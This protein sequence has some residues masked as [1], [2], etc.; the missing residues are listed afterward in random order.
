MATIFVSNKDALPKRKEHDFYETERSLINAVIQE[1]GIVNAKRILDIG[2]GDGRWGDI[3]ASVNLPY[4]LHGI[5]IR[6]LPKPPGYT[7][8]FTADFLTWDSPGNYDLIVS[9]PP[10]KHAEKFV[11]KAWSLLSKNGTIIF[12][13][14]LD[15]MSSAERHEGLWKKLPP[16]EVGVLSRRP[17]FYGGRTS[18]TNYA[19][20]VWKSD[21]QGYYIGKPLTWRTGLLMYERE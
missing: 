2:A 19:I 9:N 5:D 1:Y 21:N 11:W 3:A 8:W 16:Y 6:E 12:L 17:S 15:F 7:S 14:P 18:G 4:I 13:L 20:Y 10:Y